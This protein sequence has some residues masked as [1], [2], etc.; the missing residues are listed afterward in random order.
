[1]VCH[2]IHYVESSVTRELQ[3][4]GIL[5]FI[6]LRRRVHQLRLCERVDLKILRFKFLKNS[7]ITVPFPM[8]SPP[9]IFNLVRAE[10]KPSVW[11]CLRYY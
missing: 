11:G 10:K 4:P 2:A 3:E 9:A 5:C 6:R 7:V 8:I 1:M